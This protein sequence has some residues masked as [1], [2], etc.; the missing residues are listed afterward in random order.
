MILVRTV[1]GRVL[2]YRPAQNCSLRCSPVSMVRS[3]TWP[4]QSTARDQ[5]VSGSQ[6]P[7]QSAP[8]DTAVP[9][10]SGR[11]TGVE[12]CSSVRKV[13]SQ[14]LSRRVRSRGRIFA[15]PDVHVSVRIIDRRSLGGLPDV[16]EIDE[17]LLLGKL[18][19]QVVCK[20]PCFAVWDG[21]HF[22]GDS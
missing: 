1:V 18:T 16:E 2:S 13:N 7:S 9:Q 4:W 22:G 19:G 8:G 12:S 14:F 17:A 10:C 3:L 5:G 6:P 20:S 21:D 11:L 15:N